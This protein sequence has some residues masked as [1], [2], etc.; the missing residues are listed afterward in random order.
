MKNKK[1]KRKL[2]NYLIRKDI[3]LKLILINFLYVFFILLIT[4]G[5]VLSPII[6]PIYQTDNPETQYQA[7][8]FFVVIFER[9]PLILGIIFIIFFIHQILITH[10]I[11]GPIVNFSNTFKKI[12]EGDLTRKVYLR[13][14][15]F[16]NEEKQYINEMIDSLT[17]IIGNI[18]EDHNE[19]LS[20][21][22]EVTI[23]NSDSEEQ[24]KSEKALKAVVKH[25]QL[26][27]EHL[28]KFKLSSSNEEKP[29]G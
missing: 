7:A 9:L 21:L 25:A 18:K 20:A 8:K 14:F 23:K 13:R 22:N 17:H 29:A 27:N 12:A 16:F 10:T 1:N 6:F 2:K 19:L 3:Q 26:T 5:V 28:S 11:C 24:Q 4:I 15:D